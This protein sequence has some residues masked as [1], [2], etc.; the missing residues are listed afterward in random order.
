MPYAREMHSGF[1]RFLPNLTFMELATSIQFSALC[2]SKCSSAPS[3]LPSFCAHLRSS[4]ERLLSTRAV[5]SPSEKLDRRRLERRWSWEA[6]IRVTL[7]YS[8]SGPAMS[9]VRLFSLFV[10]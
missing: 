5:K 4:A 1:N 7:W 9:T 10:G 8:P 3:Y 2:R 6:R